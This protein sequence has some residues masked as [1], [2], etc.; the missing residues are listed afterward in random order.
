LSFAISLNGLEASGLS[1]RVIKVASIQLEVVYRDP[2][3][4]LAKVID[5]IEKAAGE[6]VDIAV[7]PELILSSASA[8]GDDFTDL[9]QPIP[10]PL[11]EA[12]AAEARSARVAVVIGTAER[13]QNDVLYNSAALIDKTG[14]L[15]GVY[16][17]SHVFPATENVFGLG[18]ELPVFEMD[19]GKVA[20]PICYDLEFPEPGRVLALKGAEI[21]LT[22]AAHWVTTGVLGTPENFIRTVYAARALENRVPLVLCDRVGFDPDLKSEFAGLSRIVDSEGTT[23]KE[24]GT[25]EEM[26]A[27]VI[28]LEEERRRRQRYNYFRDRKPHLYREI[29]GGSQ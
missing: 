17:K 4:T 9:A 6:R 16:R 18:N 5:W 29:V 20:I 27:D 24:A 8:V 12:V 15:V 26:I 21:I 19:F 28:D 10:G 2:K 25:K 7:F 11:T 13:A 23:L 14:K 22:P 1:N 3:G